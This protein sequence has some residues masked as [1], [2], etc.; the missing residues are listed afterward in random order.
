MEM[1]KKTG[2]SAFPL[3]VEES[4]HTTHFHTG[5]TLRDYFA[6][7]ADI[8]WDFVNKI[9]R[10]ACNTDRRDPTLAE[11]LDVRATLKYQEADAMLKECEK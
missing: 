10:E 9:F 5:M 4:E 2:G 3:T 8:P 11:L 6:A 7:K 1:S